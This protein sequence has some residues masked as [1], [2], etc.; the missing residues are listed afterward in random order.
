MTLYKVVPKPPLL[1]CSVANRLHCL[2]KFFSLYNVLKLLNFLWILVTFWRE[3]ANRKLRF[4]WHHSLE[5]KIRYEISHSHMKEVGRF[6]NRKLDDT[7]HLLFFCTF[8]G[9]E[10]CQKRIV[11]GFK[12]RPVLAECNLLM[13]N[14]QKYGKFPKKCLKVKRRCNS[15][16]RRYKFN[17][18][19]K[20][21][22][23]NWEIQETGHL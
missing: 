2:L 16:P 5:R 6:K 4:G 20:S 3:W 7:V 15:Y 11:Q 19:L 12:V 10:T 9:P 21:K 17:N 13:K 8:G 18:H 1:T 22:Q 23:A 14:C